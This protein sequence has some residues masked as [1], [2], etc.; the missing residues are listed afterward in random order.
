[1]KVS[2]P[3]TIDK[4]GRVLIPKKVRELAAL[5]PGAAVEAIYEDGRIILVAASAPVQI[6]KRGRFFVAMP[7]LDAPKLTHETVESTRRKVR[8]ERGTDD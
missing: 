1:M 7:E 5:P 2:E 6:E 4:S 8:R 3:T